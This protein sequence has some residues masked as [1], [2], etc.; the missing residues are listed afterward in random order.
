MY[1]TAILASAALLAAAGIAGTAAAHSLSSNSHVLTVRLPDGSLERIR[2]TGDHPPAVSFANPFDVVFAPTGD[3]F[4][5]A[6]P[7]AEMERI[8][9]A[10]DRETTAMVRE[11]RHI[12]RL[13]FASAGQLPGQL[14]VDFTNL[15]RGVQGYS[16]VST[17]SG[18]HVCTRSMEYL[19]QG[20]GKP[21]R[22][23]TKTS[24]HCSAVQSKPF[25]VQTTPHVQDPW[26]PWQDKSGVIRTDYHPHQTIRPN[27][28][29]NA[30]RPDSL[31][32]ASAALD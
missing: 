26:Q 31:R 4:G 27:N 23:E 32:L 5:I 30:P 9:A 18:G 8:S 19:S 14:N 7:F 11:A 2:Y 15:P 13:A 3:G 28:D 10:M 12:D 1:R 25:H 17:M 21:P 24:G 6:S 22:I 16:M 20:P 29:P